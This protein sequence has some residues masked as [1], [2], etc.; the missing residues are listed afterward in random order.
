V[1]SAYLER[2]LEG[3]LGAATL[4]LDADDGL[5]P[6]ASLVVHPAVAAAIERAMIVVS[7][8]LLPG[9]VMSFLIVVLRDRSAALRWVAAWTGW[10][11]V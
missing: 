7:R 2:R 10:A 5:V 6:S 4:V 8:V 11:L 1:P 9:V 3:E